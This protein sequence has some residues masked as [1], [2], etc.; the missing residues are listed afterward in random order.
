MDFDGLLAAELRTV[1]YATAYMGETPVSNTI[2]YSV[3]TYG[4]GRTGA[5]GALCKALMAYSDCAK[6]FFG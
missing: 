2:T 4:N 6:D 1:L 3:D 5:L